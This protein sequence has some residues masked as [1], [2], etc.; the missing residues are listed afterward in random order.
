M[1]PSDRIEGLETAVMA[2]AHLI[3]LLLSLAARNA[4]DTLEAE[5]RQARIIVQD[6]DLGRFDASEIKAHRKILLMLERGL[7]REAPAAP[8]PG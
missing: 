5:L 4:G 8:C 3:Q 7:G 1:D 2:Q 6:T